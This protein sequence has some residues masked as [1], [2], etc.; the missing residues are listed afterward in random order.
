MTMN[1][2]IS[3]NFPQMDLNLLLGLILSNSSDGIA[4]IA[5]DF[6]V[7]LANGP[8]AR[9]TGAP[10]GTVVCNVFDQVFP[11]LP[12]QM[13]A[14]FEEIRR[15][16]KPFKSEATPFDFENQSERD[17]TY[18]NVTVSPMNGEDGA[19]LGWVLM[20][21]E[22]TERKRVEA[23]NAKL[24]KEMAQIKFLTKIPENSSAGIVLLDGASLTVKWANQAHLAFLDKPFH[25]NDLI[26]LSFEEYIPKDKKSELLGMLR[27]V[28]TTFEPICIK[29]LQQGESFWN[30]DVAPISTEAGVPDLVF[31]TYEITEQVAI[32]KRAIECARQAENSLHQLEAVIENM[33]DGVIIF[34]LNGKIIKLNNAVLQLLGYDDFKDCP[35]NLFEIINGLKFYDLGGKVIP[36]EELPLNRIWHGEIVRNYEV[37]VQRTSFGASRFISYNGSLIKDTNQT[38][39]LA[40]LTVR[41]VTNREKLLRDLEQ[42]RSMLQTVLEQVPCGVVMFDALSF[43]QTLVNKKYAEIWRV[44]SV[45][46][47]INPKSPPGKLFHNDGQAYSPTELPIV[48]SI[49]HGETVSNEEMICQRKDGSIATVMCNSTP[50][51]DCNQNIVAG[52]LAFSDITELKEATTKAALANQLQQ[53]IEFIPDGIFV[54]DQERK[55]IAWNRAIETLTGVL[56]EEIVGVEAGEN[57]FNGFDQ[58]NITDDILNDICHDTDSTLERTGDVFSKQVLISSLNQRDNLLLDIKATPIQ[59]ECGVIQ[60]IIEIIRDITSQKELETE[61]IRMQKLE[62]LG[63]LAGGIAHDFNNI[64][65]AILA[66]LQLAVIKFRKHQ[67]VLKYLD[68]TIETTWKASCLTKQLLTFAKGGVP[69]KKSISISK[70][71]NETVKFALSGSNVKAV[72]YLPEDLWPVD[73]DEGQIT[74]VINNLTINAEQAMPSGGVLEIYGENVIYDA[75][76]KY[77]PGHFVKLTVKDHGVG[78]SEEI[79][80]QIFDPFF[81]TKKLG[82]G[83][84]LSTSYSIIKKH[85][86]YLEVESSLGNGAAFA[87]LLPA[88][89]GEWVIKE[90]PEEINAGGE[91]KILLMDDEDIIR[92]VSSEML[93]F[94]G[95]RVMLARDGQEAIELYQKADKIGD[96][97]AAVIMDLTI[98]GGMGGLETMFKLRQINPEIKAIVSSGYA[99]D[100]VISDYE[101]YGFSGM[102]I[103]P[104]KFEDLIAVLNKV[105]E[106]RQFPL[107]LTY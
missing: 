1:A 60:G 10:L 84:G 47:E 17:T 8:M 62:S 51:F 86:G 27:K 19:F 90:L 61:T 79:I 58:L 66:N 28:A 100:P 64:L 99:N 56:K 63:I 18:W 29:L 25:L 2:D 81:T 42:E 70:L 40:V 48:R 38:P 26:G 106:K 76:G 6:K 23:E 36:L 80:H 3:L 92:N 12:Q 73:A 9:M 21:R 45:G 77:E 30:C 96:P 94:F 85:D 95:Y 35:D 44:P 39:V 15:T 93:T 46:S 54:V 69:D 11:G 87:I 43:K 107:E 7:R 75:V 102:L 67:D 72:F 98:P 88:S 5:P 83:L 41:D 49:R 31:V 4:F 16:G 82:S 55:V 104:Y 24:L 20:L 91:A 57:V 101:R 13:N 14:I 52:V 34:D 22:V 68:N 71:V 50:I 103:K 53:I 105:I 59:N 97:F 32:R 33:E 89:K 78:I 37:I 65:A 74:Q